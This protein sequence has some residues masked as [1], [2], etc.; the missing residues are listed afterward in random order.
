MAA[1][2]DK[3]SRSPAP[4]SAA[5]AAKAGGKLPLIISAV[6]VL[7]AAA[8]GGGWYWTS[9]QAAEAEQAA[10]E[11]S[12]PKLPAPAQY[13]ALEPPFVVNLHGA[14]GGP[15]YLQVE[16]QLMTRDSGALAHLERHAPA[17][18]ACLLMLL[19]QQ[20]AHG[21]ADRAGKERLQAQALAEVRKL[22]R[23]ETGTP[24]AEDLLFTSFV[25]Q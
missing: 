24:A 10:A 6:A 14:N 22:M 3:N 20:D 21:I 11:A 9:R 25:T 18:R 13:L 1:A 19:A 12:K 2:A 8:A 23:A 16:I 5:P 15:Q 17:I 7:A 4:K